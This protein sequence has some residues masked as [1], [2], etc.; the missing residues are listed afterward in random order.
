MSLPKLAAR[1]AI[2]AE[3]AGWDGIV[4]TDSQNL[5]SDVYVA[6]AMATAATERIQLATGVTNPVTRHPAVTASAIASIQA[7]SGGRAVLGIGRGD[8]SL[9]H[10]GYA[11]APPA[12][13]RRYL[14]RV[15][16]YLSGDEVEFDPADSSGSL[17]SV[18]AL[19][20]AAGPEASQLHWLRPNQPKVPVDVAATGP[21]VIGIS[22]ELA[23]R[24]S[25]A[26]GADPDRI[27]W[28]RDLANSTKPGRSLGAYLTVV[29]HPDVAT[30]RTLAAGGLASFARFSVMHGTP[31][32][33]VTED[34][35]TVMEGIART[36]DMGHHFRHGSPQSANLT[37]EFF[38]RFG[39]VGP[40]DLCVDRLRELVGLGLERLIIAGAAGGAAPTESAVSRRLL[41]EEVVPA[42]R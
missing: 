28:A 41:I 39:I 16:A 7:E 21:K 32:G 2:A 8:S 22:A 6:M 42:L 29:P 34:E 36:Y 10:L 25:F 15:Q 40:V 24:I 11:P 35:R 23:E 30:A 1:Q 5:G 9:A 31:T 27:T 37:P 17:H 26:V 19:A 3:E 33:P 12:V 4:F 18:D 13:F 20:L 38:D 14:E